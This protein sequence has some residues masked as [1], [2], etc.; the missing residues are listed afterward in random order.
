M[1]QNP[2]NQEFQG[3]HQFVEL[4]MIGQTDAAVSE[5][6]PEFRNTVDECLPLLTAC[7]D[8]RRYC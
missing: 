6:V 8:D 2:L 7:P 5:V 3:P 4:L 1:E